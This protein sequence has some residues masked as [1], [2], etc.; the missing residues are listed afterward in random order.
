M[1]KSTQFIFRI[2]SKDRRLVE[3]AAKI[4]RRTVSD[5][6]RLAAVD[7]AV[8]VIDADKKRKKGI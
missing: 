8:E 5:F 4:E 3:L 7:K 1:P 6:I 2:E